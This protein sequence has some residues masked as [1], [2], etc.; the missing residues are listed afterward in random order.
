MGYSTPKTLGN[1][2][3]YFF[4]HYHIQLHQSKGDVLTVPAYTI[5]F[6]TD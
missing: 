4:F 3:K 5:I 2:E 1:S 6:L